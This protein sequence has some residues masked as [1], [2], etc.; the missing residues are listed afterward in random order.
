M[1][2]CDGPRDIAVQ[3]RV[4]GPD[5]VE[6]AVPR[7]PVAVLPYDRD[8][9]L[10]AL[11]AMSPEPRPY[12]N[13]LDSLFT[14]FRTPYRAFAITSHRVGTVRETLASLK[15]ALD[16]IPRGAP[17]YHDK[18]QQFAQLT[19][20]LAVAEAERDQ[21]SD[22][23]EAAR[24]TFVPLSDSLRREVRVWEDRTFQGYNTMVKDLADA[25]GRDPVSDTTDAAGWALVT[26]RRGPWWV[27]ARAWDAE[28]PNAEWY[29]NVLVSGDTL[30]LDAQNG[31][32]LP[33]Y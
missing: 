3:V 9:V 28:D 10:A 15:Q 17:E 23:L 33:K 27:Y 29:W 22:R 19:Q 8:S 6:A 20:V 31:R 25:S 7:L 16:S 24:R 2:A 21:A 30:I 1:A 26:M 32:R 11:E 5:G 13:Q 18:F 12:Q 14:A 4:P